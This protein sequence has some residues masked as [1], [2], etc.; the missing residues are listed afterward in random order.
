MAIPRGK[1]KREAIF[2]RIL[3][4][5]AGLFK[6][7][8]VKIPDPIIPKGWVKPDDFKERKRPCDAFLICPNNVFLIEAKVG[9]TQQSKHQKIKDLLYN[10]INKNAYF[11]IRKT[12]VVK[13]N[14]PLS[15]TCYDIEQKGKRIQ[16]FYNLEEIFRFFKSI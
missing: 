4:K 13:R 16:R 7:K 10:E 11:V 15:E 2:E 6:C 8:Y 5:F 14:T 9:K 12:E 1:I 3:T